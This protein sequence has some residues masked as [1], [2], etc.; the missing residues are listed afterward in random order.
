MDEEGEERQQEAREPP[1]S[2]EFW[3]AQAPGKWLPSLKPP[4]G[5]SKSRPVSFAGGHCGHG[6]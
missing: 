2:L 3:T 1:G 5:S 4:G 6:L